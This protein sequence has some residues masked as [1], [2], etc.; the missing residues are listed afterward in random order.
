M[1]HYHIDLETTS[2]ADI[3]TQGAVA[4]AKHSSTMILVMAIAKGSAPPAVWRFDKP[5]GSDSVRALA[6]LAKAQTETG[7]VLH[8]YN[9]EFEIAVL[10]SRGLP[11]L[12]LV[13]A[14]IARATWSDTAVLARRSGLPASLKNAS[15]EVLGQSM[16]KNA[17][18]KGLI[19]L[20]SDQTKPCR[21]VVAGAIEETVMSSPVLSAAAMTGQVNYQRKWWHVAEL[22]D[23]FVAYCVQDVEVERSLRKKLKPFAL[24]GMEAEGEAFTREMNALGVPVDAETA[25]HVERIANQRISEMSRRFQR[26]TGLSPTQNVAVLEWARKRGYKGKSLDKRTISEAFAPPE[27]AEA[28]ALRAKVSQASLKKVGAIIERQVADRVHGAHIYYGAQKTGR[29][30]AVGI[31]PQNMKRPEKGV[32]GELDQLYGMLPMID[33]DDLRAMFGDPM[34]YLPSVVRYLIRDTG[35]STLLDADFA[36]IEARVLAMLVEDNGTLDNFRR[37]EDIYVGF[38]DQMGVDRARGKVMALLCQFGGGWR[39]VVRGLGSQ[40]TEREARAAVA[41]YR[42]AHPEV[43]AGWSAMEKA[44]VKAFQSPGKTCHGG[45]FV[46]FR[47]SRAPFDHMRIYLPSGRFIVLPH[48]QIEPATMFKLVKGDKEVWKKVPGTPD[49][50]PWTV[51]EGASVTASFETQELSYWGM[52]R[53]HQY[54]RLPEHG[55]SLLQTATSGVARDLLLHGCLEA[56]RRGFRICMLVHDEA[57]ALGGDGSISDFIGALTTKPDW[58]PYDFPLEADGAEVASYRK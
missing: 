39:A 5:T 33:S 24:A 7:A 58:V 51:P 16:Q 52:G 34:D 12:G 45:A 54:Q 41:L 18:G 30:S 13:M 29:W 3:R 25:T 40:V 19:G 26:L 23:R 36:S 50:Y 2:E 53:N 31:Q 21:V 44:F 4:Y 47:R 28:L 43:V 6:M 57:L 22:F 38:A 46:K 1:S 48:P 27:V 37:G 14:D 10:E 17:V 55:A 56:R 8:A 11:D 20:F 9:A 35:G 32:A 15:A 42:D 49:S